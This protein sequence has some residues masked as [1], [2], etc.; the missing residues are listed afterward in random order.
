MERVNIG[1]TF[2]RLPMLVAF[3][4]M[5]EKMKMKKIGEI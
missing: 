2:G 5:K 1:R 3:I 4:R